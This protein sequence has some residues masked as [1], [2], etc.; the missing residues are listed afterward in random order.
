[1][2]KSFFSLA[3]LLLGFS[4]VFG[5]NPKSDAAMYKLNLPEYAEFSSLKVT[6]VFKNTGTDTLK[7]I[8]I[9]WQN[10]QGP[11]YRYVKQEISIPRNQTWPFI[12][13]DDLVLNSAGKNSVKVWLSEPNGK[14]D[15]NHL[16]DTLTQVIQVI[17][18]YP[19][20]GVLLEDV[21]GA[22]CGYCPRAPIIYSKKVQPQFPQ[23][24]FVAVH[25]GDAMAATEARDFTNTYVTGVP[26]GFI[27]R[28]KLKTEADIEYSPEE[29]QTAL[30]KLD[31][32][33]T[34]VDLNVY[35]YFDAETREWKID[36]IA[37]FVFDM[38]CNYRMNCYIIEDSLYG[39]GTSWAQRNFFNSGASD[40]FME[41]QGAGDPI[42][43][44][45]HHHVVRKMLGGS[46]G[47]QGIIPENVKKGDRYVY[48]QTFT[49][50]ATWKIENLYLVG[51]VQQ[52]DSDKLK[53]P[54]INSVKAE[55]SYKTGTGPVQANPEVKLYPNPVDDQAILEIKTEVSASFQIEILNMAGITVSHREQML[56]A[57]TNYIPIST[58][59]H[60]PGIYFA[61]ITG[62]KVN[63]YCRF[64]KR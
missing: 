59:T 55:L 25:T 58:Q 33:F 11:V 10:N 30:G 46:W 27:D 8:S 38:S 22:W 54:I 6:G 57:G 20:K 13:P 64:I 50:P 31:L 19:Q 2:F 48:S 51:I 36:V 18:A 40:P 37:D 12:C 53:R 60:S 29:W 41:L 52:W 1:M 23:T 43:G 49:A 17:S 9:N 34:P 56:K 4:T 15:E 44:Y 32:K 35:N 47:Q 42:P 14:T 5:Q 45:H 7:N 21:T 61:H 62:G 63:Q 26:T 3:A 16:N 28:N 39:T 24:I